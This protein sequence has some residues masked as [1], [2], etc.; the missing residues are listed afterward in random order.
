MPYAGVAGSIEGAGKTDREEGALQ[1][2]REMADGVRA[3]PTLVLFS[4]GVERWRVVGFRLKPRL[5][6]ELEE[7]LAE[8]S[9]SS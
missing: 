2:L 5:E 9:A 8:A 6:A 3:A 1:F 7:A 4:G